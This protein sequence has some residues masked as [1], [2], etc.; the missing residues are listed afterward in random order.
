[1]VEENTSLFGYIHV[2]VIHYKIGEGGGGLTSLSS[3]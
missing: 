2:Q 3:S 1:M